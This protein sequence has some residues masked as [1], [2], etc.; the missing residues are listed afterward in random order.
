MTLRSLASASIVPNMNMKTWNRPVVALVVLIAVTACGGNSNN[1]KNY[2]ANEYGEAGVAAGIAVTAAIIQSA[3][4]QAKPLKSATECC[5]ICDHCAFPCGDSC[6]PI[7]AVCLKPNG[8]ACYDSQLPI[9]ER[10]PRRDQPCLN[11][12]NDGMPDNPQF[13]VGGVSY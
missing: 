7:G 10:P 3:R 6:I 13:P 2:R 9:G 11:T 4:R 1:R 5:A 8:C 12:P